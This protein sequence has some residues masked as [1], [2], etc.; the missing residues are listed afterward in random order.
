MI[1]NIFKVLVVISIIGYFIPNFIW[2]TII[3]SFY[4]WTLYIL[5]W[6]IQNIIIAINYKGPG[7]GQTIGQI[8]YDLIDHIKK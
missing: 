8:I 5:S 2:W 7:L 3:I 1:N 4:A 6:I